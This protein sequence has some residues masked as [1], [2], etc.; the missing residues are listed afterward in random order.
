MCAP[1]R[2]IPKMEHEKGF[3]KKDLI[4]PMDKLITY[5]KNKLKL[6]QGQKMDMGTA[7]K[8]RYPECQAIGGQRVSLSLGL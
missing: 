2:L 3:G 4:I 7:H 1:H 8:V 6:S 5:R